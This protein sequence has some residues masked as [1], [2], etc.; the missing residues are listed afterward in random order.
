MK[1]LFQ[2]ILF[3]YRPNPKAEM[4]RKGA[5]LTQPGG[6]P[7]QIHSALVMLKYQLKQQ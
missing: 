2:R 5:R 3:G 6:N 1:T 4:P 7:D